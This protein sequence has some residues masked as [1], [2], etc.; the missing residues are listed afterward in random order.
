MRFE[1]VL[2]LVWV[3]TFGI[4]T[5]DSSRT[6]QVWAGPIGQH[7]TDAAM[8][9]V[10][11]ALNAAQPND[12]IRVIVRMKHAVAEKDLPDVSTSTA[13]RLSTRTAI[14]NLLQT[15]AVTAQRDVMA[16]LAAPDIA[17]FVDDLRAFWIINGFALRATPHVIDA[18]AARADVESVR[19]DE[20]VTLD[21][22]RG[23]GRGVHSITETLHSA[24][25]AQAELTTTPTISY[26]REPLPSLL[27]SGQPAPGN[28]TWGIQKIRADQVWGALGVTGQGVVV[29]NI[30]SGVDWQ[31]PA[32]LT[33][34]RG[35]SGGPVADHLHNWFDATDE[36]AVYPADPDGHGTHTMGTIVGENGIGV[37]PGAQW[38]AVKG[39]N[40]EGFG[41]SSWLHSAF[42]FIL[43]P[44]GDPAYA[45][46]ILNNSWGSPN[47][48]NTEFQQD[49]AALKAAGIFV[50]FSN[51]NRGPQSGSVGAPASLP[52]VIS[53]GAT[54]ID[55]DIAY[56]SS[57]GPSPLTTEPKPTFVA[58][59][60]DVASSF[61]G[62]SYLAFNG[63]SMAAPHV[64]GATA[65]LMSAEPAL[66]TSIST[67]LNVLTRTAVALTRTVPNNTIGWGRID[68][69]A[70]V[71]SVLPSGAIVGTVGDGAQPIA[72]ATV[73]ARDDSQNREARATTGADGS[74]SMR[75]SPGVYVVQAGTFGY[76][77]ATISPR[78]VATGTLAT[79][80]LS[81][82]YLPSGSV[83]GT[84]R[85]ANTGAY[86]TATVRAI[87]TPKMS[88]SNNNCLPCRYA[89][90]L[91]A[92]NYVIEARAAGYMVQTRTVTI[93]DGG[94]TDADFSLPPIQRIAFVDSG[95]FYH[96]SAA[97]FY[98]DSLDTLQLGY[99]EIRIKQLPQDTPTI[100]DLLKYDTVIWSA[101]YDAPSLV[102]A[103]N[104][105]SLYLAAGKNLLLTGQDIAFFDGGG[106]LSYPPYF[107]R[108]N[109]VFRNEN[110]DATYV[111]GA[112]DS[113]M[114][115]AVYSFTSQ[116]KQFHP[117]VIGLLRPDGGQLIA[118]YNNP[119][120]AGETGAG[121]WVWRCT[122]YRSAFYGFG[123][124]TLG[125]ADRTDIISKT[126]QAFVAPRPL[127]GVELVSQ[128]T[129]FTAAGIGQP[130]SVVTHVLRLRNT[131][132][133]GV[134]QT[135]SLR[136]DGNTWPTTLSGSQ[137]T[138]APCA[139][140]TITLTVAIPDSTNWH[141]SDIVTIT[142]APIAAPAITDLI[143]FT[144]KTPASVLLVDDD[145]FY[146]REQ[147]YLSG[148]NAQSISV[149]RWDAR[150]GSVMTS[151]PS[152]TFL[153]QYPIVIWFNGYDWYEPLSRRDEQSLRDYLNQ[154]GRLFL[155]SQA[156]LQYIGRSILATNYLGVWA[157]DFDETISNTLGLQDTPLGASLPSGSLLPFPYF[158][159]LSTAVQPT[160]GS[161][162][163]LLSDSGQPAGT[164]R[165][166]GLGVRWRTA[167]TPFAF[168]AL[169]SGPR[170][171]LLNRIV[172]WLSAFGKSDFTVDRPGAR[173]GDAV[174]FTLSLRVDDV[175]SPEYRPNHPT[176]VTITLPSGLSFISSTLPNNSLVWL[177]DVRAGDVLTWHVAAQVTGNAL[178]NE[179][180]VA[181]A[182]V[183]ML[184]EQIQ[185]KRDATVYAGMP[186][187][188][189][190]L[191]SATQDP[192]VWGSIVTMTALITNTS[193]VDAANAGM[194]VTLPNSYTLLQGISAQDATAL[195]TYTT[196]LT[197]TGPLRAGEVAAVTVVVRVPRLS[198]GLPPAGFISLVAKPNDGPATS[199]HLWLT[200]RTYQLSY[201][202]VGR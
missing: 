50:V 125:E 195:V 120:P 76:L 32:L 170:E 75:V 124:E 162:V 136:T 44:N 96:A 168:E 27:A 66:K 102:D 184:D 63:T 192:A 145:R 163:F 129:T 57:R 143:S 4:T 6:P 117:D 74:F 61:P 174:H 22:R 13:D 198:A 202:F 155:A 58:P 64:A 89:L 164:L 180:Q 77:T 91:P 101:P 36:G 80:S 83:R 19:L 151:T 40:R 200:P 112:A 135:I 144:T 97:P 167:L 159:N 3:S 194:T 100:T 176:A 14:V 49:L 53:V 153:R 82:S 31:H 111:T 2:V 142:A 99:D 12:R 78:F 69:Y 131:G 193:M 51:G 60:V 21:R 56:F 16:F 139:T 65:L 113:P 84:V 110:A 126:L 48:T 55:D 172:G 17:P 106:V 62:G 191:T 94:L 128:D 127:L 41:L 95:A 71:I 25:Q 119:T 10:R 42:Q 72:N 98:R 70:A 199:T 158:W 104:V 47:P 68:A 11:Q 177:G 7:V 103:S 79:V 165:G 54:D 86:V 156:A 189:T 160:P 152:S 1:L 137:F 181:S 138:L 147:D 52:G 121:T 23:R 8:P 118:N 109:A 197:W 134:T 34:Y 43:A 169:P 132:D 149:D 87:S 29:A 15:D 178:P 85:D 179:P 146:N 122:K 20:I 185:Y 108:L 67:T 188:Q 93:I 196:Q 186:V 26:I 5:V 37:A 140:A 33:R 35:Y 187:L 28:T 114:A 130:G 73:I 107:S 150:W 183:R 157:P 141:I 9:D 190:S 201:P 173:S 105:L 92:G 116:F 182:I 81:L 123:L 166:G 171:D 161:H 59:G 18:L 45:P 133:G 46:D 115:G 88:N 148:L 30:D 175:I 154:G 24:L 90:D 39:L 38:M